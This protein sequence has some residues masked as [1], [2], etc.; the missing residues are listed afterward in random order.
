[1]ASSARFWK[2]SSATFFYHTARR[3]SDFEVKIVF[4]A[5]QQ[6]RALWEVERRKNC[7]TIWGESDFEGKK[8]QSTRP[9]A[10]AAT[11]TS[12]KI[13]A[14]GAGVRDGCINA[15]I[16]GGFEEGSKRF[17]LRGKRWDFALCDVDLEVWDA[18]SVEGLQ[19]LDSRKCYLAG[20]IS[21]SSFRSSYASGKLVR[22][23]RNT[24]EASNAKT[25]NRI[26]ILKS[27]VCSTCHF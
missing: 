25:L 10:G 3:E 19:M 4:K 6:R 1:M 22:S 13:Y 2:F 16:C 26:V 15:G 27:N 18:Q 9:V 11:S 7:T 14:A 5:Q 23:R 12:C 24:F 20:I 21:R 8:H 17:F